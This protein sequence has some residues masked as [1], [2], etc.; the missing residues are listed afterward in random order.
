MG[1]GHVHVARELARR[2]DASGE[3]AEIVDVLELAGQAGD[4]LRRT[5]R[6][7]LRRAPWLYDAAMRVWARYAQ[8]FERLIAAGSHETERA[9]AAAV[10]D[11]AADVVVSTYNLAS[12]ALGRLVARGEITAPV[13]TLVTDPGAHPY[14]VSR[15]V[16]L[17]IAPLPDTANRLRSMGARRVVVAPPVLRPGIADVRPDRADVRERLAPAGRRLVLISAGSWAAGAVRSAVR[18][19]EGVPGV[20]VLVLCGRDEDLY[21]SLSGRPGVTA[22]GWTDDVPAYLRAADVVVDNAGGL[23]CWE[24]IACRTPVVL[25]APLPGHGRLN[26]DALAET[27]LAAVAQDVPGLR[28]LVQNLDG[29]PPAPDFWAAE[30]VERHVLAVGK[31]LAGARA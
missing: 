15:S 10:H 8:P 21:R 13:V 12:Q 4:R 29:P 31:E 24:A 28:W 5:Y 26:A 14:W 20:H 18:A 25:F 19:V 16:T 7:L 9:L 17:H 27:G 30:P 1:A 23:T 2:I 3:Q 6:L 22:I 11:Y